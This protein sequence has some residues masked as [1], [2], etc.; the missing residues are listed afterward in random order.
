MNSIKRIAR[1]LLSIG[2][3]GFY[4]QVELF[5]MPILR[6]PKYN[7]TDEI[8]IQTRLANSIMLAHSKI[9]APLKNINS[10]KDVVLFATGPSLN[11]YKPIDNVINI[12]VNKA[13]T[14]SKV[15]FDYLFAIDNQAIKPYIK[16]LNQYKKGECKKFYG[17]RPYMRAKISQS[18]IVE[19]EANMFYTTLN[20]LNYDITCSELPDM[21]SVIFS[22]MIFALWTCPRRIYLVG[23]DCS[24]GYFYNINK[25]A[26]NKHLVK[27][28]KRIKEYAEQYY[29]SVE[30]IS[31]NPVGLKG[32]FKD[33]YQ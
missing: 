1:Y 24:S 25:S 19:A 31:I 16:D 13:F 10:E 15:N 2:N 14:S 29:P 26:P 28:W 27:K 32:L 33:I 7:R 22:A 23:C 30:I 18:D 20:D 4:R 6:F 17:I 11:N 12:G 9:F 8:R 21:G 3:Y 5:G